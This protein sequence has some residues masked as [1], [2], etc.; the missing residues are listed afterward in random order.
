MAD[1]HSELFKVKKSLGEGGASDR[2]AEEI[3]KVISK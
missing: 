1:I 2:A 3:L